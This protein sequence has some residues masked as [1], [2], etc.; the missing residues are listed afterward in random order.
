MR[1]IREDIL[2]SAKDIICVGREKDY[3][4][5][6][7]SFSLIG[8][9]WTLFLMKRLPG[10]VKPYE[11]AMMLDLMKTARLIASN[12]SHVDSWIDKAGYAGCG[13]EAAKV[14]LAKH[15]GL[16]VKKTQLEGEDQRVLVAVTHPFNLQED[17]DEQA[18]AEQLSWA[19]R[20]GVSLEE[21]R[22]IIA[23]ESPTLPPSRYYQKAPNE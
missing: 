18:T 21:D 14:D 17:Q 8:E 22:G 11:V 5:P 9:F 2:M 7:D 6:E 19:A 15:F 12:G 13:A 3:G 23:D 4:G 16:I 10:P 1:S 20:N